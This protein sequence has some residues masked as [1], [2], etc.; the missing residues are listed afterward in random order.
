MEH[1]AAASGN[2]TELSEALCFRENLRMHFLMIFFKNV[3]NF[4]PS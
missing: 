2:F 3:G 4:V 1:T